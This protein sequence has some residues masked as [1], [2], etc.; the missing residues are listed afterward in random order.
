MQL[1]DFYDG[2]K[3]IRDPQVRRLT[4]YVAIPHPLNN[5]AYAD[6]I[7]RCRHAKKH[8]AHQMCVQEIRLS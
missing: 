8:F 1:S 6:G 3:R 5:V 7:S 4:Q 2:D